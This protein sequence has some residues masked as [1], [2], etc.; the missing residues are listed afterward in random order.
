MIFG[1]KICY[2]LTLLRKTEFELSDGESE[3]PHGP[4]GFIGFLIKSMNSRVNNRSH[5]KSK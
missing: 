5:A 2:E 1:R 3:V 4:I